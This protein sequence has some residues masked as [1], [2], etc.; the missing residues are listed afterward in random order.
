MVRVSWSVSY[1]VGAHSSMGGRGLARQGVSQV[2]ASQDSQTRGQT[3][4]Q[5]LG[6]WPGSLLSQ[7]HEVKG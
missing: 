2:M 3:S 5:L 4:C 1:Q 7:G 6:H